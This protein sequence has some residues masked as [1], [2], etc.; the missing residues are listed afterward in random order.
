MI[1]FYVV[2]EIIGSIIGSVYLVLALIGFYYF[3]KA[4]HAVR[5]S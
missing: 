5:R 3:V 1:G 4:I 2:N